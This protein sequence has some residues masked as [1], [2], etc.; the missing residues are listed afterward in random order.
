MALAL[1]DQVT[2]SSVL[3]GISGMNEFSFLNSSPVSLK[4]DHQTSVS[5][6]AKVG[7]PLPSVKMKS[8][9]LLPDS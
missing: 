7:H 1:T 6:P 2:L 5:I 9:I 3:E 4:D 8:S